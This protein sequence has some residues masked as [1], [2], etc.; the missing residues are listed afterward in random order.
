MDSG[1]AIAELLHRRA[2]VLAR[3][4]SSVEAVLET[5]S[6]VG[7]EETAA[8][9]ELADAG[10][11]SVEPV[12]ATLGSIKAGKYGRCR[13]CREPISGRRQ[14]RL[15]FAVECGECRS[16]L[17]RD[18]AEAV[19][20]QHLDLQRLLH[21]LSIALGMI[22]SRTCETAALVLIADLHDELADHFAL[23]EMDGYFGEAV[24]SAPRLARRVE[25]MQREHAW[26]CERSSD[27]LAEAS[28]AAFAP[29]V[30]LRVEAGF[31]DLRADLLAHET[32]ENDVMR[33]ALMDDLGS[34]D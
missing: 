26:F 15:P 8:L 11:R 20:T 28:R 19:S 21:A 30:W 23:E 10:R 14:L 32:A 24:A 2:I 34:G 9:E 6:A 3:R 13:R 1:R 17:D 29:G 25:R 7:A 4:V 33:D 5:H 16:G 31:R 18:Y 22:E 12:E 27:L